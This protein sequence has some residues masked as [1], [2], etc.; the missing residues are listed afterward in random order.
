MAIVLKYTF[1]HQSC[2]LSI[3]TAGYEFDTLCH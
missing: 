3:D 1:I 2:T